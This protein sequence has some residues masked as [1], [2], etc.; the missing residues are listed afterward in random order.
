M[1]L[2]DTI[3]NAKPRERAGATSADRFDYQKDWALCKLLLLHQSSGDY[4]V[5]FD[6]Y[7]DV[8]VLNGEAAP[9]KIAFF[10]IKALGKKQMTLN[11][12]LKRDQ[13]ANGPLPSI[14]GKLYY[15]KILFPD[16]TEALTLV[17]STPFQ[18]DLL[19]DAA[20]SVDKR[21]LCCNE[22]HTTVQEK[23]AEQIKEEHSLSAVPPFAEITYF[24]V[25]DLPLQDHAIFARGKLSD[26]LEGLN[27]SGAFRISIA[28][29]AIADGIKRKNNYSGEW[30]DF[31]D[32]VRAKGL[33]RAEFE[34]ILKAVGAYTDLES[35]W[36]RIE[37]RLNT[38]Q[39]P[40][41]VL[42]RLRDRFRRYSIDRTSATDSI[43]SGLEA[44]VRTVI[45]SATAPEQSS[46]LELLNGTLKEVRIRNTGGE[47]R[48][49]D[50]DYI[51]AVGLVAL[52]EE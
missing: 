36:Q 44:A 51:R 38:E 9:D 14:I 18:V 26:F 10:Q 52:Y 22:L 43:L 47:Y 23:I 32:F 11:R 27:P 48:R 4:V 35:L 13:G 50:D 3:A 33:A 25:S 24:E 46:T 5:A 15:G 42:R 19:D 41:R 1:D 37:N 34:R 30:S 45:N 8:V 29:R 20:N 28:Y 6:A 16:H 2:R 21:F 7:D 49:Y 12:I 39:V 17:S 40:I 31:D